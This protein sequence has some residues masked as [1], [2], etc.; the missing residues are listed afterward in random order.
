M[1]EN[2]RG[3]TN[4]VMFALSHEKRNILFSV[5]SILSFFFYDF[6][7]NTQGFVCSEI[8]KYQLNIHR[9]VRVL[10]KC[11]VYI[12]AIQLFYI[13]TCPGFLPISK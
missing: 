13:Q 2:N 7:L 5:L 8:V 3:V 1:Q 6:N 12:P 10:T 4:D 9:N 11:N